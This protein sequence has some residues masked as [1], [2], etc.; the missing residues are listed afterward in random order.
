MSDTKYYYIQS[1]DK[2][3][4][5]TGGLYTD[6]ELDY[7]YDLECEWRDSLPNYTF[8]E[9]MEIFPEGKSAAKRGLKAEIK[10]YKAEIARLDVAREEEYENKILKAKLGEKKE[11]QRKSDEYYDELRSKYESKVK[12]AMFKLAHLEG[13]PET[14]DGVSEVDIEGAKQ[15]PITDFYTDKLHKSGKR[16]KGRCP[17]HNEKTASFTIYLDQNSFYCYGCH[18]GGSVVDFVMRQQDL[19]F[20]QA[21][22]LLI[23]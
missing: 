11:L 10:A 8:Q 23:K 13:K 16:A 19:S 15:V 7:L 20:L 21:V 1:L 22:K 3:L 9:L 2:Y 14:T 12:S 5:S 17:F 18:A 4:S 6:E